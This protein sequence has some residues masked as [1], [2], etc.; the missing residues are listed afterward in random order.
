[1]K[2]IIMSLFISM[3]LAIPASAMDLSSVAGTYFITFKDM[4]MAYNLKINSE[5]SI[6]LFER[7][8]D[9]GMVCKGKVL[10]ESELLVLE[11]FV[12]C[13]P[14]NTV[15]GA[16]LKAQIENC[17]KVLES[18]DE[19]ARYTQTIDFT[20][21][22]LTEKVFTAPINSSLFKDSGPQKGTF[23]RVDKGIF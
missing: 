3:V 21:S 15:E 7:S 5:G 18:T 11:S 12:D 8:S 22:N 9:G 20:D 1:M 14:C 13:T 2:T 10:S 17:F 4:P 19:K 16:E 23:Q 6:Q